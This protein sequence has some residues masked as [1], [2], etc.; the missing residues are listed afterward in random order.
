MNMPPGLITAFPA[1]NSRLLDIAR[2]AVDD[3]M[4][5]MIA[6]A[7]YG[8]GAENHLAELRSIRDS[9]VLPLTL[10]SWEPFTLTIFS[11]PNE[12][13]GSGE[14]G[15]RMRAFAC[16]VILRGQFEGCGAG[17]AETA[18]ARCLTSARLLGEDMNTAIGR[19][20]TW[21]IPLADD[22]DRWL[23]RVGLL[24][25]ATRAVSSPLKEDV[26]GEVAAWVLAEEDASRPSA[27]ERPPAA[28]GLQQGFWSSLAAELIDR[29][30]TVQAKAVREDLSLLGQFVLGA[31]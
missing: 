25:V 10:S 11:E 19:F 2:R 1:S 27:F 6:E 5:R 13:G 23:F 21:A 22:A 30:A 17:M 9:G 15:H 8:T 28:F 20:L 31:V 12:P 14:P 26:L 4:L 18:L 16:A 29:A 7:D 24:I 3:S